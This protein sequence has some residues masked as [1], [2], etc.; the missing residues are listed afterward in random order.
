MSRSDVRTR[1]EPLDQSGRTDWQPY[2]Q[3]REFFAPRPVL[4]EH[5]NG[6][7]QLVENRAGSTS[8]SKGVHKRMIFSK[9]VLTSQDQR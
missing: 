1:I 4:A 5:L 6:Q 3:K 9:M 2:P 7:L 8:S